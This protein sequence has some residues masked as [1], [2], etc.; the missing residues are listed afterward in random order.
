MTQCAAVPVTIKRIYT[1]AFELEYTYYT[2]K[3]N[4][5]V[6]IIAVVD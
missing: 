4:L 1:I 3:R 6:C 2:I 5:Y